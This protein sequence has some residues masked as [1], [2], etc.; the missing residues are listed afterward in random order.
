[1]AAPNDAMLCKRDVRLTKIVDQFKESAVTP[2]LQLK[3]ENRGGS[4][5]SVQKSHASDA[6]SA[7]MGARTV[8]GTPM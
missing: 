7:R 5:Q 3:W 2:S 8:E 6:R 4:H 1:M